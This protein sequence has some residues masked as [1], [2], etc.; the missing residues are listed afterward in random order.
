MKIAI[1]CFG[2]PRFLDLTHEHIKQEFNIPGHDVDYFF[3]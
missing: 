3:H 1:L 2:Q